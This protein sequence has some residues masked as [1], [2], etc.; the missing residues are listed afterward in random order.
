MFQVSEGFLMVCLRLHTSQGYFCPQ[1]FF[2]DTRLNMLLWNPRV[3]GLHYQLA[4]SAGVFKTL[5]LIVLV[6]SGAMNQPLAPVFLST[7]RQN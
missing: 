1:T 7:K 5:L 4:L 3:S 2:R 6:A